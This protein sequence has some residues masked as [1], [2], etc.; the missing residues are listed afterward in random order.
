MEIFEI[1]K[2][3]KNIEPDPAYKETAKRAVLAA[4][5]RRKW[6]VGTVF[7]HIFETA[8]AGTLAVFFIMAIASEFSSSPYVAPLQLSVINPAALHAEAQAVD[9]QIELAKLTYQESTTTAQSTLRIAPKT[10]IA[11]PIPATSSLAIPTKQEPTGTV[12]N[13]TSTLNPAVSVDQ[14]LKTLAE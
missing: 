3:F 8:I 13:G 7:A 4:T 2:Q 9:M 12:P 6:S 10:P 1:L 11:I 14:A 5:P